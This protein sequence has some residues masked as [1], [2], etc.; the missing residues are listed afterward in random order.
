MGRAKER[1]G[2]NGNAGP[3]F[4]TNLSQEPG[5]S[6]IDVNFPKASYGTKDVKKYDKMLRTVFSSSTN[7]D[8]PIDVYST[9]AH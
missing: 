4:T 1:E 8:F 2:E 6:A 9:Y 7:T 3:L 5:A